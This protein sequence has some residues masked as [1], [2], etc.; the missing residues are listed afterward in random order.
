MKTVRIYGAKTL[1]RYTKGIL[2]NG[3]KNNSW[4]VVEASLDAK[5]DDGTDAI[6]FQLHGAPQSEVDDRKIIDL[7]KYSITQD[8]SLKKVIL[9]HRPDELQ[10]F[11]ELKDILLCSSREIVLVFLGDIHVNDDFYTSHN[12]RRRVIPHGFFPIDEQPQLDPVIIGSHTTWGEMRSLEHIL[13]LFGE[14]FTQ[15]G[16]DVPILGYV[17]GK[18]VELLEIGELRKKYRS[19]IED[20]S[21]ELIDVQDY[22]ITKGRIPG[23]NIVLVNPR[24]DV[25]AFGVTYNV[26][27]Y[28]IENR[29]RTG[30]SSGTLHISSG[31]PVILEMNG[32]DVIEDLR[33]IKV[34]YRD[35]SDLDSIDFVQGASRIIASINDGSYK[36][37]L[38]HNLQQ[39]KVWDNTRVAMEYINLFHEL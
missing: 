16:E 1:E 14:V 20:Y 13:K 19:L 23:R 6:I 3:F 35:I 21:L 17:G 9:L 37:M 2:V 28:Y 33:V 18:P 32:A 22:D 27:M 39:A 38:E 29:I 12:I 24:N 25:P 26:Q 30:E 8:D 4:N 10:K 36:K 31:I 7:I 5:V 11:H 15:C 34:P